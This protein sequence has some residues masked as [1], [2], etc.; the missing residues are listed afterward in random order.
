MTANLDGSLD[1]TAGGR[2]HP[3]GRLW[4]VLLILAL[5]AAL[6][7]GSCG[8]SDAPPPPVEGS[9]AWDTLPAHRRLSHPRLVAGRQSQ[10]THF[11]VRRHLGWQS[12]SQL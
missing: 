12:I 5:A 2:V 1:A 3:A 11:L 8:P 6:F 7:L 4:P 10:R 9:I